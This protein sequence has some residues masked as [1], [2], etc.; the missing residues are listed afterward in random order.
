MAAPGVFRLTV[1]NRARDAILHDAHEIDPDKS[2][3]CCYVDERS[4]FMVRTC[5]H[6]LERR[7]RGRFVITST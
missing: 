4:C 3:S 2:L 1:W 6:A 5:A 7:G